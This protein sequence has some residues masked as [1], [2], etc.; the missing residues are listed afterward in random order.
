VADLQS[1]QAGNAVID[2][3]EDF[4]P[5]PTSQDVELRRERS[6]RTAKVLALVL[7]ILLAAAGGGVVTPALRRAAAI[8]APPQSVAMMIGSQVLVAGIYDGS[9]RLNAYDVHSGRRLWSTSLSVLTRGGSLVRIGKVAVVTYSSDNVHGDMTNAVDIDTGRVVWR[10]PAWVLDARNRTLIMVDSQSG[11]PREIS[12]VDP[13]TGARLWTQ[14]VG[15]SCVDDVGVAYVQVCDDGV[16]RV[17][18]M[19]TGELRAQ[20]KLDLGGFVETFDDYQDPPQITQY[21]NVVL[22]GHFTQAEPILEAFDASTLRRLW[23]RQYDPSTDLVACGPLFCMAGER[24]ALAFDPRT[25]AARP[26]PGFRAISPGRGLPRP[27]AIGGAAVDTAYALVPVGGKPDHRGAFASAVE[28]PVAADS[29][30]VLVPTPGR[31]AAYLA[32]IDVRNG[33]MRIIDQLDGVGADSCAAMSRYLAC[34]KAGNV[35][36]FWV[37]A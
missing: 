24:V 1:G 4:T 32:T 3:G 27:A 35:L 11:A 16:M 36:Q 6:S 19:K 9:N 29:E 34:A 2:L 25:G 12:A 14:T 10:S 23:I 28:M 8:P 20:T 18:D 17:V 21:G 33:R 30:P 13:G 15:A 37:L 7:L 22:V 26:F 5:V 31:P